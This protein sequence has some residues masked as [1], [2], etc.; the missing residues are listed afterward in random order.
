[1]HVGSVTPRHDGDHWP[2]G[3]VPLHFHR[4]QRRCPER[5]SSRMESRSVPSEHSAI[6]LS[7]VGGPSGAAAGEMCQVRP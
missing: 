3:K 1:M 2:E 5:D 6:E 4:A 7:L